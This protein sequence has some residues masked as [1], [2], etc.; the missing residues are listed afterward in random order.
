[1]A[2]TDWTP[3]RRLELI[4][5]KSSQAMVLMQ[6]GWRKL[7]EVVGLLD[8]INMLSFAVDDFL[9]ANKDRLLGE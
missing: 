7:D 6:S 1:M 2:T 9:D 8:E 5:K 3:Q 4:T